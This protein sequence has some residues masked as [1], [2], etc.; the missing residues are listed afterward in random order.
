MTVS[1]NNGAFVQ[2]YFTYKYILFFITTQH[3]YK[4]TYFKSCKV[5]AWNVI[6]GGICTNGCRVTLKTLTS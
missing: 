1:V 4:L 5:F 2:V 3:F 6:Y